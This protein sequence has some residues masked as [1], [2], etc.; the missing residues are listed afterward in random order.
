MDTGYQIIY[1]TL[2]PT[3]STG[4]I[5]SGMTGLKSGKIY[6]GGVLSLRGDVYDAGVGMSGTTCQYS[7]GTGRST[8]GYGIGYC[9]VSSIS[10]TTGF[11][12]QF[13]VRDRIN[14]LGTGNI[15]PLYYVDNDAPING[16]FSINNGD[17]YTNAQTTTLAITQP[18]DAGIGGIEIGYSNYPSPSNWT[19]VGSSFLHTLSRGQGTKNVYV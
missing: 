8:A 4:Y 18:T 5:A 14:N 12:V 10:P 17:T 3:V 7:L 9:E 16:D 15:S 2:P 11:Q 19:T 1:D 6:F 13:R